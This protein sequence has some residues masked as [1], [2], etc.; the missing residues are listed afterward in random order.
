MRNTYKQFGNLW[1]EK[2]KNM[3]KINGLTKGRN[4]KI[5]HGFCMENK[6]DRYLII[7]MTKITRITYNIVLRWTFIH[8]KVN[9]L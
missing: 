2:F 3:L 5:G 6:I 7:I 9:T 4:D 8:S 1:S